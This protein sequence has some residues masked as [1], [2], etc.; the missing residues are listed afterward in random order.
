ML[1]SKFW[2]VP[3]FLGLRSKFLQHK[4]FLE[5]NFSGGLFCAKRPNL[6]IF[7]APSFPA[8]WTPNIL[9]FRWKIKISVTKLIFGLSIGFQNGKS[10]PHRTKTHILVWVLGEGS[11]PDQVTDGGALGAGSPTQLY[12]FCPEQIEKLFLFY[13]GT[14]RQTGAH[15]ASLYAQECFASILKFIHFTTL[16]SFICFA[17]SLD[18][19]RIIQKIGELGCTIISSFNSSF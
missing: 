6:S 15:F 14:H 3:P 8:I 5:F 7:G 19:W 12:D 18:L 17:H 4:I 11:F 1:Y 16:H 10:W 13:F 9:L 2:Y